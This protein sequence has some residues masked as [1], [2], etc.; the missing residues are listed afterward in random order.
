MDR[1]SD[2]RSF[3]WRLELSSVLFSEVDVFGLFE[4]RFILNGVLLLLF[5]LGGA[6]VEEAE[7]RHGCRFYWHTILEVMER[8]LHI[9]ESFI[10][11]PPGI[12]PQVY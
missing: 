6:V 3:L 4:G 5:F 2:V 12:L 8:W 9:L 7:D 10:F 1:C 11:R